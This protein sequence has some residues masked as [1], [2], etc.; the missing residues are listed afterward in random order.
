MKNTFVPDGE[1]NIFEYDYRQ[2]PIFSFFD[3]G[4]Y[5]EPIRDFL[6]KLTMS[7]YF[8][9]VFLEDTISDLPR[10]QEGVFF[11]YAEVF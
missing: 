11:L 4:Y 3:R 8:G 10:L 5:Q 7:N 1:L 9:K 6:E 2:T